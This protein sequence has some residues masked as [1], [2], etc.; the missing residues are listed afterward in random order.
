MKKKIT[1]ICL[2]VAL[3]AIAVVGGS[4]AYFTA[5]DDA[6][7]T[8]TVG[9]VSIELTEPSWTNDP[10]VYPGEILAK[11]PT[12]TNNGANPCYVRIKVDGLNCLNKVGA[13][14]VTYITDDTAGKLGS[15]WVD[16]EDG[17]FY[18]TSILNAGNETSAV[19]QQIQIPTD[20]TNLA[21]G[22]ENSFDVEVSAQAVQAQGAAMAG[23]TI[24]LAELQAWFTACMA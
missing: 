17:Y 12:V 15:G 4:L 2:V 23:N 7:N 24:T 20:L 9:N 19:F 1:A 5:E 10:A 22:V 11:D 16:G 6:T 8:F 21:E 14:D 13:G 18:Y 3:A